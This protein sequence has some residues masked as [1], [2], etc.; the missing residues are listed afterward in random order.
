MMRGRRYYFVR[1]H[2]VEQRARTKKK[3]KGYLIEVRR[4]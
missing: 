1:T 3:K 2:D 4:M